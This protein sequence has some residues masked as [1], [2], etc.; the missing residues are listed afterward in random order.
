MDV[1]RL[2]DPAEFLQAAS[3]LLLADEARHNVMLGIATML[4]DYPPQYPEFALWLARRTG[5]TSGSAT[6][7]SAT[8]PRSGSA[9][10]HEALSRR[11]NKRD[12][13]REQHAHRVADRN[14]LLVR[15]ALR[16][17]LLKRRRR[18]LDSGVE[19]QRREL[20]ALGLLDGLGLLLGEL[21]QAAKQVLGIA[22]ERETLAA[23]HGATVPLVT[24]SS[25]TL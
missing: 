5:S 4:R 25:G 15:R 1:R 7:A 9:L 8:P 14:G 20:L 19:R 21:A 17:H 16:G 18:Q 6:A 13:F 11:R 22:S 12:G 3:P 10:A 24:Q 23:F 2:D